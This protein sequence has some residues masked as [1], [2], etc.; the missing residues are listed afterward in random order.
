VERLRPSKESG[1]KKDG[2][3][4]TEIKSC[5]VLILDDLSMENFSSWAR[6]RLHQIL[7]YRYSAR[8]ATV[9]TATDPDMESL[10]TRL[11]SRIEDP[12]ISN[13]VPIGAPDYRGGTSKSKPSTRKKR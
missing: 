3:T 1:K 8:M 11:R 12:K 2:I 6:E 7:N 4:M 13:V 9:I 5:P 10:D